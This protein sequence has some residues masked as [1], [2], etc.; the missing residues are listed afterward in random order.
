[1]RWFLLA[2][3]ILALP[4]T[5]AAL[6]LGADAADDDRRGAG[7]KEGAAHAVVV[8]NG[9]FSRQ[10]VGAFEAFR[11][12]DPDRLAAL[13]AFFPGYRDR[14]ANDLAGGW[15]AGYEVY[16]DLPD[17]RTVHVTVSENENAAYW[18]VGRGD[19]ETKGDFVAFVQGLRD[20]GAAGLPPKER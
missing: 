17:R 6:R 3:C 12:I 7:R 10:G 16:F 9:T 15:E 4:L 11:V 8:V 1:M 5:A 14:P 20:A 2:V 18:T 13:E 19:L